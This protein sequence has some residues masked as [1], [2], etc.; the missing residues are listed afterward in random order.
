MVLAG[1]EDAV[2]GYEK[3]ALP[4][5]ENLGSPK[6]LA[7]FNNT[8]HYGFSNICDLLP[9]FTEECTE[10][11]WA[12]IEDV[13]A[14]SKQMIRAFVDQQLKSDASSEELAASFWSDIELVDFDGVD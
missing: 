3:E 9:I 10:E 5:Y 11:G 1:T 14:Y 2:L 4:T 6:Y 12:D 8:G 13:Q 7:T